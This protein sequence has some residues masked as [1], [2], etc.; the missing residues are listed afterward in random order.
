MAKLV[1]KTYGEALFE[2]AVE[3]QTLDTITEEVK[4]IQIIFKENEELIKL[5]NHPKIVNEEKVKIIE[6]IFKGRASDTMLGFLVLVIEK[7]R[8]NEVNSI[9]DYFM[10]EVREFRNIGVAYVT[11]AQPLSE[12]E[13]KEIEEKLLHITKYVQFEMHYK[14]DESLIGGMIIRI[15][16]RIVDSSIKTRLK[17]LEQELLKLQLV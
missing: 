6:D 3:S 5:L 15:G 16:D 14:E 9:F 8:Y 12:E 10:D 7:G 13:K 17:T 1:S 2:L 4:A 11:S